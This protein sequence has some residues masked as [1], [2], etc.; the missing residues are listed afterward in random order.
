MAARQRNIIIL[1]LAAHLLERS[2][3]T[4]TNSGLLCK[5]LV[6]FGHFPS[7]SSHSQTRVDFFKVWER[8]FLITPQVI[9]PQVTRKIVH[10]NDC[11]APINS[12]P[13]LPHLGLH[14]AMVG[15]CHLRPVLSPTP[16]AWLRLPIPHISQ[17][18]S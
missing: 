8:D 18:S 14:G 7:F 13:H 2:A 9:T 12:M 6:F 10:A 16:W 5:A 11:N 1:S 4:A 17:L 15:I 3:K